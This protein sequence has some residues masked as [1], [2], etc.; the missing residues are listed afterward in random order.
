MHTDTRQSLKSF[1]F[2]LC[3]QEYQ[4]ELDTAWTT[5]DNLNNF[6]QS[7]LIAHA[8]DEHI[9]LRATGADPMLIQ[10]V[11]YWIASAKQR[12]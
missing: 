8:T 2:D 3:L 5:F 7:A 6:S 4:F 1:V 11:E 10:T 9:R 12:K